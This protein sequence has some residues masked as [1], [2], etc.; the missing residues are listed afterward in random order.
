M[1]HAL[2]IFDAHT[3]SAMP[4][5]TAYQ[6]VSTTG[7]YDGSGITTSTRKFRSTPFFPKRSKQYDYKPL[8]LRLPFLITFIL[9]FATCIGCLEFVLQRTEKTD[10]APESS[11]TPSLTVPSP[12]RRIRRS[13]P[14]YT[15]ILKREVIDC[16]NVDDDLE[17]IDT[18]K[19]IDRANCDVFTNLYMPYTRNLSFAQSTDLNEWLVGYTSIMQASRELSRTSKLCA[20]GQA[21]YEGTVRVGCSST[22][23]PGMPSCPPVG[24]LWITGFAL[25]STIEDGHC[26]ID[27]NAV[28]VLTS[29]TKSSKTGETRNSAVQSGG[30]G[31]VLVTA[32]P[33]AV[34]TSE[35]VSAAADGSSGVLNTAKPSST[36]IAGGS[37]GVLNTNTPASPSPGAA[38]SESALPTVTKPN[39]VNDA[40]AVNPTAT[41]A[42][43]T[44]EE[45]TNSIA[46]LGALPDSAASP[47]YVTIITNTD[48]VAAIV[49]TNTVVDDQGN[50]A[51]TTVQAAVAAAVITYGITD[52]NGQVQTTAIT[53]SMVQG[54]TSL[55]TTTRANGAVETMVEVIGTPVAVP[56]TYVSTDSS[57]QLHTVLSIGNAVPP[58]STFVSTDASGQLHTVVLNQVPDTV[59]FVTTDTLGQVLTVV[60]VR[61]QSSRPSSLATSLTTYLSTNT[62]GE[63]HTVV[64]AVTK[65][66]PMSTFVSTN[67]DGQK[68]TVVA[69]VA[70]SSAGFTTITQYTSL[71][72]T[73][74][75]DGLPT[76]FMAVVEETVV[77]AS[78]PAQRT[79]TATKTSVPEAQS[80]FVLPASQ[81]IVTGT[82]NI[83]RYIAALYVPAVIAIL[84][85][86]LWEIVFSAIKLI[87]PFE[88][89]VNN[90]GTDAH[91][92]IFAQYLSSTFTLDTFKSLGHGNLVPLWSAILFLIVHAGPPLAAVSMTMGSRS[93]CLID[94]K[95]YRCDPV[96]ILNVP[97]IRALQVILAL[98]L[99]VMILVVW[100][101]QRTPSGILS[102]T[103]SL[104]ALAQLLTDEE[105]LNRVQELPP[106]IDHSQYKMMLNQYRFSLAQHVDG[107]GNSRYGILGHRAYRKADSDEGETDTAYNRNLLGASKGYQYQAVHDTMG[108][109]SSF[110]Q[111]AFNSRTHQNRIMDLLGLLF[112]VAIFALV[113]AHYLDSNMDDAYNKFMNSRSL[114]PKLLLVGLGSCSSM[115]LSHLERSIRITEPFRRLA[116]NSIQNRR[117]PAP[118]ETTVLLSRSGTA[119]SNVLQCTFLC[120]KHELHGGRMIFQ[121]LISFTVVLCDIM[122]IAASGVPY[123]LAM[124]MTSYRLSC[125]FSI[126]ICSWIILIYLLIIFW[127]RNDDAVAAVGGRSISKSVGTIGG[128]MRWLVSGGP[129]VLEIIASMDEYDR[130]VELREWK[131]M[132]RHGPQ[133][134]FAQN[135]V[136]DWLLG[137]DGVSVGTASMSQVPEQTLPI[138]VVDVRP[139]DVDDSSSESLIPIEPEQ[140]RMVSSDRRRWRSDSYYDPPIPVASRYH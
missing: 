23:Y 115:H 97:I 61:P 18:Y 27:P 70:T 95:D 40:T 57:G 96:W 134:W 101:T 100:S 92:S 118:A 28:L 104:S 88:R 80:T 123:N 75:T 87:E 22:A 77:L 94:G 138:P 5:R 105:L 63:V 83:G 54:T 29:S 119:Y 111:S 137:V 30:L 60:S 121:T 76:S 98:G 89:M 34:V 107:S 42:A 19:E 71:V 15:T 110:N 59:T 17:W 90:V 48:A 41:I 131:Q 99:V 10:S 139:R 126:G 8:P 21:T 16:T 37:N 129:R 45:E 78:S 38:V 114:V 7:G 82:F 51:V 35:P 86:V 133:V 72:T 44:V 124:T 125:Y 25:T 20:G 140:S 64:S 67:S 43:G 135:E 49:V 102:D 55:V 130:N 85:R 79:T 4:S 31:G 12:L 6:S 132:R 33:S 56:L 2:S 46:A 14:A 32:T 122:I 108:H 103:S 136:G 13:E 73:T 39:T 1:Q 93:M 128:L 81:K 11:S 117:T 65:P 26:S 116:A 24:K 91:D 62:L 74:G 50:S 109:H 36:V 127:W 66:V 84:I 53:R 112:P 113:L 52:A 3:A 69:P 68:V 47:E 106:G 58:S 120:L 9:I